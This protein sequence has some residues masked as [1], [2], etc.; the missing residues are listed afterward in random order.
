[1]LCYLLLILLSIQTVS[2]QLALNESHS[3]L[4]SD[5]DGIPDPD[6]PNEIRLKAIP[7]DKVKESV[8]PIDISQILPPDAPI[9][10]APNPI[11]T[12]MNEMPGPR[13]DMI[14]RVYYP[15]DSN[16]PGGE[17]VEEVIEE[18]LG[19]L[20]IEPRAAA[21]S[22]PVPPS[23]VFQAGG[24]PVMNPGDVPD[25]KSEGKP[26]SN[27]LWIVLGVLAAIAAIILIV[28]CVIHCRRK[29]RMADGGSPASPDPMAA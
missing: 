24:D 21:E 2:G 28:C 23:P 1:M 14:G 16:P 4:D 29:K 15:P 25:Q 27:T 6:D 11:E 3:N 10:V 13:E 5:G 17:L 26:A 8:V 19:S 12:S 18:E 7:S 20:T 9:E 22:S